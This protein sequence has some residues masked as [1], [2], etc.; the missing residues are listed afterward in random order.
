VNKGNHYDTSICSHAHLELNSAA[1]GAIGKLLSTCGLGVI[2]AKIGVLDKHALDGLSRLIFNIFQPCLLFVNVAST[3]SGGASDAGK[4]LTFVLPLVAIFQIFVGYIVGKV[5]S[6]I[7]Y[8]RKPNEDSKQ[9]LTCSTFGNSGPLPLVFTD[10]LLRLHPNKTLLPKSV[11]YISLYLL[12]WSP[13]F[14]VVAQTILG[15]ESADISQSEKNK[16]LLKRILRLF[17]FLLLLSQI[18]LLIM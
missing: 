12:G 1:V 4:M 3:V 14:W 17:V 7:L 11:A 8:G 18:I 15:K 13:L 2:A 10:A 5:T 6:L 9:L 16:L